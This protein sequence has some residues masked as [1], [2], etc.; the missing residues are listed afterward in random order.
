MI[1]IGDSSTSMENSDIL[2]LVA[3]QIEEMRSLW[4]R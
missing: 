2:N 4:S 1:L 3:A